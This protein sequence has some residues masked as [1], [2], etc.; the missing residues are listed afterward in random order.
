MQ[1]C[2]F[3]GRNHVWLV[4]W[5]TKIT[6]LNKYSSCVALFPLVG[7]KRQAMHGYPRRGSSSLQR[8]SNLKFQFLCSDNYV[9]GPAHSEGQPCDSI[10]PPPP[11]LTEHRIGFGEANLTGQSL[12]V[13]S[14]YNSPRFILPPNSPH[15]S[16][17]RCSP[18]VW[19]VGTPVW[20]PLDRCWKALV[21]VHLG[22]QCKLIMLSTPE[23]TLTPRNALTVSSNVASPRTWDYQRRKALNLEK[24]KEQ[25]L[26]RFGRQNRN[27]KMRSG[28]VGEGMTNML[29]ESGPNL[30]KPFEV[31]KTNNLYPW[32]TLFS[33][34]G[35]AQ[36]KSGLLAAKCPSF[37]SVGTAI[38]LLWLGRLSCHFSTSAL[39]LVILDLI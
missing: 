31:Q 18:W 36:S 35:L 30:P 21:P 9:L 15:S 7:W 19:P 34:N 10:C 27:K 13:P 25:D 23:T 14:V 26:L 17:W 20:L 11:C 29:E 33:P 8:E 28:E 5:F 24:E 2:S 12:R 32:V 22:N 3:S 37:S 39:G 6:S 16:K 4:E 38:P 1:N